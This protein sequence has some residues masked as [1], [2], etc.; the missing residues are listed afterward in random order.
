M[1]KLFTSNETIGELTTAVTADAITSGSWGASNYDLAGHLVSGYGYVLNK[2]ASVDG[3]TSSRYTSCD[4]N[5]ATLQFCT[6]PD[7]SSGCSDVRNPN[8][9]DDDEYFK[10]FCSSTTNSYIEYPTLSMINKISSFYNVYYIINK[11]SIILS[12]S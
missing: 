6:S 4:S 1:T 2:C 9:V 5:S 3:K 10:F 8:P 7:C 12:I 11:S